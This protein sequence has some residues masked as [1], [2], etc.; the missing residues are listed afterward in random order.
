M[1][2]PE[3]AFVSAA[4]ALRELPDEEPSLALAVSLAERASTHEELAALLEEVLQR[5]SNEAAQV[6]ITRALGRAQQTLGRT[7]EGVHAWERLLEAVPADGEA[8]LALE[9]LHVQAGRSAEVLEVLRRQLAVA[10]EPSA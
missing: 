6:G 3:L 8:L 1:Q 5:A 2:N 10:E 7:E 4:R 9:R